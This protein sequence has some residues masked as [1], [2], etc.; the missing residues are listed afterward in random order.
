MAPL[1]ASTVAEAA[2]CPNL[3]D[4]TYSSFAVPPPPRCRPL[5]APTIE[6]RTIRLRCDA[7]PVNP[8]SY[9]IVVQNGDGCAP[10]DHYS[11]ATAQAAAL[12]ARSGR[13][14]SIHGAKLALQHITCCDI[15]SLGFTHVAL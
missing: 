15:R 11:P 4:S 3:P 12:S 5:V 2:Y 6:P 13:R 9:K 10:L 8:M 14:F 7:L 1:N